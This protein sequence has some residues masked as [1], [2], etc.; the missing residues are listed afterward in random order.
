M[1]KSYELTLNNFT[2]PKNL[3]ESRSTFRF[4]IA[5]R[6]IEP[7]GDFATA[8]AVLPGLDSYWECEKS[9][10]GKSNYVRHGNEPRFDMEKIDEWDRL[11]V[12]LKARELHS[13][14]VKVIDIEKT[15]GLLDKIKDYASS[16]I[17]SFLGTIKT[18]ATGAVPSPLAFTKGAL[19]DAVHDVESLTLAKLAGMKGEQ[20]LLFKKSEKLSPAPQSP[21]HLKSKPG[22]TEQYDVEIA[23]LET[24]LEDD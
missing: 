21:F 11:I 2:F 8:H 19:G 12:K 4:L 14:Q 7:D 17:Q 20:F 15:G 1:A 18:K 5:V 6:Y 16:M 23:L 10:K 24:E 9:H 13:M 3:D 22:D